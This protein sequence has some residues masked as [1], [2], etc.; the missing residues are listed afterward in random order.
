MGAS[1]W[2]MLIVAA[3]TVVLLWPRWNHHRKVWSSYRVLRTLK[4]ISQQDNAA[5]RQFGYLRRIAPFV[6]EEVVLSA[7]KQAGHR[8]P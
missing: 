5:A 3:L 7:L 4:K 2:A 6:F 1:E 8:T